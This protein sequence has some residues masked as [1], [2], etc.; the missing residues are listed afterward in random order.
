MTEGNELLY[1]IYCSDKLERWANGELTCPSSGMG[2][3]PGIED[4]L[5]KHLNDQQEA[6]S[7]LQILALSDWKCPSCK[8][9]MHEVASPKPLKDLACTTCGSLVSS[10]AHYLLIEIVPHEGLPKGQK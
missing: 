4:E 10:R 8:N 6:S 5:E 2:L 3:A 1:C 7:N 9:S